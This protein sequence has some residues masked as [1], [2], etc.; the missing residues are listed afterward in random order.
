VEYLCY[1][2]YVQNHFPKNV[3]IQNVIENRYLV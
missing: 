1:E 3:N 2:I